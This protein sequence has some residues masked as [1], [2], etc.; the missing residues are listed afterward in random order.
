M[1]KSILQEL[2]ED[3]L[4]PS[5]QPKKHLAERER[6]KK[7]QMKLY[8]DLTASLSRNQQEQFN[9]LLDQMFDDWALEDCE[10][11]IHGFRLGAR[12]MLDVFSPA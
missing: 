7:A 9:T 5:E 11:F 1:M 10:S 12:I 6:L 8:D 4:S 2:Y 3:G